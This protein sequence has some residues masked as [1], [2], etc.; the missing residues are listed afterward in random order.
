[1]VVLGSIFGPKFSYKLCLITSYKFRQTS[2][3]Y[4]YSVITVFRK[5]LVLL[6]THYTVSGAQ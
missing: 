2:D 1:M 6:Y 4:P 5:A 3:P